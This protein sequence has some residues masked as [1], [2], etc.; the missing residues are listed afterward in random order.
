MS[1]FLEENASELIWSVA[2]VVALLVLRW[3]IVRG[4]GRR[5]DSSHGTF[6]L[7]KASTYMTGGLILVALAIIWASQLGNV[8]SFVGIISAGL[9]IA[10]SDLIKDLAGWIYIYVKRPFRP[11]DRIQI[12]T[13]SGDVIDVQAFRFSLMEIGNWVDADQSTGRIL[14]IPNGLLFNEPMAN[15]TEGFP[16][17]WH[18]IQV[19]VT[20]ESDWKRAEE[21]V[22]EIIT[23]HAPDPEKAGAAAD[24][25]RT[26]T[27]YYIQFRHLTPTV[28]VRAEDSGVRL[29]GRMLVQARS[30]RGINSAV[31]R[32]IL[33]AF[34][35]EPNVALAYP[36][37]R[38]Y[39]ADLEDGT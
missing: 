8:G 5:V 14:H 11:G 17:I 34:D 4:M 3:A 1:A 30:R 35:A 15:F 7:R 28:Y 26:A 19:L 9:V 27:Q 33:D 13:H 10:L 2:A 16:F 18:E 38:Y 36:T 20:F 31:W 12:G 22:R 6:R 32:A 25:E 24:L 29:T 37:V 39:R 21:I 23:A